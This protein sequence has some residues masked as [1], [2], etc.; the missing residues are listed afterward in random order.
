MNRTRRRPVRFGSPVFR[1]RRVRPSRHGHSARRD[2]KFA[3]PVFEHLF[4]APATEHDTWPQH[5]WVDLTGRWARREAPGILIGWRRTERGLDGRVIT[6][7]QHSTGAG[8][9]VTVR[10][11]WVA[12]G[13]F[14]KR[15]TK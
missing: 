2:L 9:S 7:E 5:V 13:L 8:G 1:R 11:G 10:Q 4:Y 14:G 6:A 3:D 12:A 15:Q